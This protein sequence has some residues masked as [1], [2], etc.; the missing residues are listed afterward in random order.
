MLCCF[1]YTGCILAVGAALFPSKSQGSLLERDGAIVG[2]GL[3]GQ[4]FEN[5]AYFHGRESAVK[6]NAAGSGGSNMAVSNPKLYER[7][8]NSVTSASELDGL[9]TTTISFDRVTA[10]GSGLDPHITAE[11]ARQQLTRVATA[12]NAAVP[13]VE[14]LWRRTSSNLFLGFSGL[15]KL[16]CDA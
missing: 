4:S 11:N 9:T 15:R 8:A 1:I 6:Y 14:R 7:M 3:I 2:S 10:S 12:R 5:S 13:E 16:I